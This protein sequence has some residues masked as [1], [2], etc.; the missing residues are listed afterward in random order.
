ME[1]LYGF[2]RI[3]NPDGFRSLVDTQYFIYF[4]DSLPI[5][6]NMMLNPAEFTEYCWLSPS[7]AI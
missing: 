1:D 6:Q 5:D 4:A 7:E 3:G 2:L